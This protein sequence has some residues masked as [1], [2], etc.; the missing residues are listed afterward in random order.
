MNLIRAG[1]KMSGFQYM[2]VKYF[3]LLIYTVL[4]GVHHAMIMKM[5]SDRIYFHYG[6]SSPQELY[7]F[8][9]S[10]AHVARENVTVE[11]DPP[12]RLVMGNKFSKCKGRG[13]I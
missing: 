13:T 11:Q 6:L 1:H 7:R 3:S 9:N 8:I 5:D 2:K 10:Q 12:Y 4:W